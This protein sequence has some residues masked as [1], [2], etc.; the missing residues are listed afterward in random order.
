MNLN[1]NL[2]G[3][4]LEHP[5]MNAAGTVKV[6]DGDEGALAALRTGVSAVVIGS[7]TVEA[8]T[9]N[10]G[11][12]YY[13]D[14]VRSLNSLGLPNPGVEYWRQRL[15]E[16]VVQAHDQGRPVIVSVAGFTPDEYASLTESMLHAG[17]DA[18]ELN[19]GCPNIWEG[20]QQKDIAS[21][22]L[23]LGEGILNRVEARVGHDARIGIKV[24]PYSNPL[25][26]G[27]AVRRLTGKPLVKLV[28]TTN[29]FPNGLL[30]NTAG[31]PII[32]FKGSDGLA[33]MAGPALKA[34]GLGQVAQWK[35]AVPPEVQVIGVG[36]ICS[37]QDAQDYLRVGA[38]A[39]QVATDFLNRRKTS[40]NSILTELVELREQVQEKSGV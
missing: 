4:E 20:G 25:R 9:G 34:I 11:E 10:E 29:T 27:R 17:T 21:F 32:S 30:L 1:I 6:L 37:G 33:G 16:F 13:T 2:A 18:V 24:S 36:G 15:P 40:I 19:F 14:D 35:R 22:N 28:T 38:T 31:Q 3:L 39:V 8:R 12:T 5:V 26:I 7:I 23:E